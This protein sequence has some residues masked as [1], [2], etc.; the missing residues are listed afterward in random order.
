MSVIPFAQVNYRECNNELKVIVRFEGT[1]TDS[2]LDQ[3]LNEVNDIYEQN[4]PFYILYDA[5]NIGMLTPPQIL[6]QV[7]FMRNRDLDSRRLIKKCAIVISS[8]FARNA[9][10]GI[11]R[12]KPPACP[13][14]IFSSE[15]EA[16][17]Y[18]RS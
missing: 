14:G 4:K 8:M 10:D 7:H 9:L 5:T 15:K 18:L 13:V 16:K 17:D 6:R 12:L 11:F 3:Y 1:P 2:E